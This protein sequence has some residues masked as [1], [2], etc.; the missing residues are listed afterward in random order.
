MFPWNYSTHQQILEVVKSTVWYVTLTAASLPE[1][2][3]GELQVT[4]CSIDVLVKG[5]SG[6]QASRKHVTSLSN[7]QLGPAHIKKSFLAIVVSIRQAFISC[8]P[9]NSKCMKCQNLRYVLVRT[10][11]CAS[12]PFPVSCNDT[13]L[14]HC[15]WH[16]RT[17]KLVFVGQRQLTSSW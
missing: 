13:S 1:V 11:P 17:K 16:Y 5:N 9:L 7:Y 10:T 8:Q 2:F 4:Q 6:Y 14:G 12:L 3:A 15:V